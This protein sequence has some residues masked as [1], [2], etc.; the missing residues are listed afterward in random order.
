MLKVVLKK[1]VQH[2]SQERQSGAEAG[3]DTLQASDLKLV[4]MGL[5]R[6]VTRLSATHLVHGLL[7]VAV[8]SGPPPGVVDALYRQLALQRVAL[9]GVGPSL[10]GSLLWA[11]HRLGCRWGLMA[12]EGLV[13]KVQELVRV[14][15]GWAGGH[16]PGQ[17]KREGRRSSRASSQDIV[18]IERRHGGR[19]LKGEGGTSG[20]YWWRHR[21]ITLGYCLG[22]GPWLQ[23]PHTS[24]SPVASTAAVAL[25][26][27][28]KTHQGTL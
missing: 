25:L 17:R 15:Y 7:V 6:H 11:M 14:G 10:L 13:Q 4:V 1:L 22:C 19:M 9:A 20:W 28:T 24:H 5:R 23:S 26:S 21:S 27:Y 16:H 3:L 8:M 18:W 2:W 12:P